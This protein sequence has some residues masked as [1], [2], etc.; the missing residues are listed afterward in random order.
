MIG[1]LELHSLSEARGKR[2]KQGDIGGGLRHQPITKDEERIGGSEAGQRE[3]R[4]GEPH[5]H[6]SGGVGLVLYVVSACSN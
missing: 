2:R 4:G 1:A 3:G 5:G 6:R